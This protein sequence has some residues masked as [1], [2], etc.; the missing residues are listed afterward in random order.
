LGKTT[1]SFWFYVFAIVV[2][3][4]LITFLASAWGFIVFSIRY[5]FLPKGIIE[6]YDIK[7]VLAIDELKI[8]D[9]SKYCRNLTCWKASHR[10]IFIPFKEPMVVV[11]EGA[12]LVVKN[13]TIALR[14]WPIERLSDHVS[15]GFWTDKPVVFVRSGNYTIVSCY[16]NVWIGVKKGFDDI[17]PTS[18]VFTFDLD[19]AQMRTGGRRSFKDHKAVGIVILVL[20]RPERVSEVVEYVDFTHA[21]VVYVR[22]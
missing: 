20:G 12:R 7:E 13:V 17:R 22:D 14:R 18:R 2:A 6:R 1:R 9:L 5:L 16:A 11:K 3:L 10:W 15:V 4:V 19:S 21:Y 8:H